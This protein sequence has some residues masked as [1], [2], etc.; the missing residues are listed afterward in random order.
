E[1]LPDDETIVQRHAAHIGLTRPEL[2][3]LMAYSKIVLYQD[4]LASDLPDA[5]LLVEDLVLYFPEPVRV[6]FRPAIE[7]HRLRREII[8]TNITNNMINR[9]RPTFVMQMSEETGKPGSDVARAFA[10]VRESFDLRTMWAD[11]E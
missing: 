6:R 3:V 10:V 9:V 11:I 7:R 8:A 4:L 2:A 1:G 5:P